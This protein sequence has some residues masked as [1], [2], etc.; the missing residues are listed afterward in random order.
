ME[1]NFDIS[2]LKK[3]KKIDSRTKGSSFERQVAKKLNERFNTTEF[4]RSPGSGAFA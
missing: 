1:D 2:G 3:K 4:M